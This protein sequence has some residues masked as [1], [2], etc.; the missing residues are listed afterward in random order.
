MRARHQQTTLGL[1]LRG[2]Y[3]L[4]SARWKT[5]TDP[6]PFVVIAGGAHGADR[7]AADWARAQLPSTD[8]PVV[9]D[10]M[11]ADWDQLGKRA[12][13]VRNVRMLDEGKPDVVFAFR[14]QGDSPGTDMMID[15]A[16]AAAVPT[17][18]ITGP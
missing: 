15:L 10:E 12:G 2:A 3:T 8:F 13:Y 4:H 16:R 5:S 11:P 7:C 17:F 9:L 18:V 14:E 1:V 6:Q